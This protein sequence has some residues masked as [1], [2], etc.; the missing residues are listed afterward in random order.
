[1]TAKTI[2]KGGVV[3]FIGMVMGSMMATDT[4]EEKIVSPLPEATQ[5]AVLGCETQNGRLEIYDELIDVDNKGFAE[6]T[7]IIT[8]CSEGITAI[9]NGDLKGVERV[10]K[11]VN[12]STEELLKLGKQRTALMEKL[13]N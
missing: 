1:M 9:S 6:A 7:K 4:K 12:A 3:L 11:N 5:S 13:T 8:S 10:T 2:L